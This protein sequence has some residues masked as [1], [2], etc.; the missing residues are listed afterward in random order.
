MAERMNRLHVHLDGSTPESRFYGICGESIPVGSYHTLFCPVYVLDARAQNEGAMGPPKWEPRARIGVYLGH[1]PFHA[2]SVALVL[3]P[4]TGLVSPQFHVVFDDNFSTVPYMK[5]GRVPKNWPDLYHN[6]RELA[7]EEKYDLATSW[8]RTQGEVSGDA[9]GNDSCINPFEAAQLA[10]P[11]FGEQPSDNGIVRPSKTDAG[12][13][14]FVTNSFMSDSEG[15]QTGKG[16]VELEET[17]YA[18]VG[19]KSAALPPSRDMD[20]SYA[21]ADF[22]YEADSH[23]LQMPTCVNLHESGLRRSAR[24]KTKREN[25]GDNSTKGKNGAHVAFGT[26]TRKVTWLGGI[27]ALLTSVE[28]PSH[29]LP[30]EP[31]LTAKF[32]NRFHECNELF[33][34]TINHIHNYALATDLSNNEVF[35]YSQAMRQP[36][37]Q[38]FIKAMAKEVGDHEERGHWELVL[39]ST[40]PEGVKTI[41]AIWSFKRKRF[42][43]GSLNK[44]K[45]RL[46]A[47]GGMQQWGENYWE[48]YSPVVNMLTVRLILAIAHIHKLESKSIDFV[49]AFPQAE[50]DVDIWMELPI[51]MCPEIDETNKNRYVLKLKKNLYGLKQ[52]SFNWFD[53]LKTGLMDRGFK[54]SQI[55]PCLYYKKGMIVL[56]YV[57]DCII[58]GNKMREIDNFVKSMQNGKENFIL[59]DEGDIDKFLGI[60]IQHLDDKRFELKQPFLIERI[61]RTLGLIDND[62]KAETNSKKTPVGKPILNKDLEGKPRKLKWNYRTAVGMLSYLQGNTRPEIAMATHQTA[63]F[64]IDPKLSHEQAIMRIGRYLLGTAD[65]GI[66]YEPD[67]SKGLECYVD[68]DFAGGWSH[69]D[70]EDAENVMSRTGY[71]IFYAGCPVYWVSK[72]QTEIALSTAEAEYIALSTALREVIPL[73]TLMKE[74]SGV[75]PLYIDK[76]N[77]FCKIFEDNQSCIKMAVAP[78]L[79]PRTKHIALKYHHFKRFVGNTIDISYIATDMQKADIFTKP[80]PDD[81]FFRLRHML[82]G[83]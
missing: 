74:I 33:D 14:L 15:E 24:L 43:D 44:H 78:K 34:G 19:T 76:P 45:A 81:A 2:G 56:T 58:V 39:R 36:D 29:P 17:P 71:V 9:K 1:S 25:A 27:F 6:S 23:L 30:D 50:L 26:V 37:R 31:S 40:L 8:F 22:N 46:C 16:I 60:E 35:T 38:E 42:P 52:A 82:M 72:L 51:G 41:K 68:A 47:H 83:W 80:L 11:T 64:C 54:A 12:E 18:S 57:D 62:W 66:I 77:F 10:P 61:C 73:M 63:R 20:P 70:S 4:T 79:T 55:D 65:R 49:L 32:I 69:A 67:P 21:K 5:E 75:F 13:V 7:T 28:M 53:K 3:N 59:T 48:T